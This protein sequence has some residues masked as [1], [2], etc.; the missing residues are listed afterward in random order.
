MTNNNISESEKC[1]ESASVA[2]GTPDEY[3]RL[4]HELAQTR[5]KTDKLR[6]EARQIISQRDGLKS[7]VTK[8]SAEVEEQRLILQET[9]D[10]IKKLE[11]KIEEAKEERDLLL[12]TTAGKKS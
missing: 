6:I 1:D 4:K 2:T 10:S 12:K 8:E 3:V 7:D 11:E 9:L 5:A